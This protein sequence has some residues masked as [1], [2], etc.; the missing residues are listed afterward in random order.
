MSKE[1]SLFDKLWFYNPYILATQNDRP[2]R[3]FK[4]LIL[5]DQKSK[6]LGIK[7]FEFVSNS[8][9]QFLPYAEYFDRGFC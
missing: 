3:Y 1:L 8:K 5:V 7:Q 6:A 4:L 9:T 2:Y